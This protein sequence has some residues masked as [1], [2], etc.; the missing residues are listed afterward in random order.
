[1]IADFQIKD[2]IDRPRFYQETFF[3]VNPKFEIILEIIFLKINNADKSFG[4]SIFK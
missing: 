3:V 4:K 1:M 2:K